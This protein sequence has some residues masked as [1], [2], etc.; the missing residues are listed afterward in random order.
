MIKSVNTR[1]VNVKYST[2]KLTIK[3]SLLTIQAIFLL[4]M[5]FGRNQECREEIKWRPSVQ[6]FFLNYPGRTSNC[7]LRNLLDNSNFV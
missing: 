1:N 2:N 4:S 5:I 3:W 7:G 6:I